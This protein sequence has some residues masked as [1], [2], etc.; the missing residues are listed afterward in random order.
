MR[1]QTGTIVENGAQELRQGT[2]DLIRM[3]QATRAPVRAFRFKDGFGE[4]CSNGAQE[5]GIEGA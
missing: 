4:D 5:V 2:G 1:E 3:F